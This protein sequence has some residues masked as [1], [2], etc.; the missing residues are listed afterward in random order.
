MPRRG[1]ARERV[2]ERR[3]RTRPCERE[4]TRNRD[5][6]VGSGRQG[7]LPTELCWKHHFRLPRGREI[8][9]KDDTVLHNKTD[10]LDRGDV[11]YRVAS[12]RDDV[13]KLTRLD[14]ADAVRPLE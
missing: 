6:N 5:S 11:M 4:T 10:L 12:H 13:G 8:V 7:C 1:G 14:R 2:N 9:L 3:L